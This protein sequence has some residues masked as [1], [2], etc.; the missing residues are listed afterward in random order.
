MEKKVLSVKYS[1]FGRYD[2]IEATPETISKLFQNFAS[3]EFMPNM[4]NLLKIQQPQNT[5][6]QILRPQLINRKL[7]CTISLLPERVDVEFSS[8]DYYEN[9][10]D[11]LRRLIALFDLKI[12]RIALN[13][14][15]VFDNLSGSEI[16]RLNS[17]LT[18]P[19]NYCEERNLVEYSSRRISR[20]TLGAINENVNV[21]RNITSITQMVEGQQ[22]IS[23]IQIDTDINTLGEL[24]RERFNIDDC[25][26]FFDMATNTDRDV[27]NNIEEIANVD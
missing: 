3:D 6:Q 16:V 4:I 26:A 1:I 10:I 19:E 25:Q 18:P 8:N 5:V 14:S 24:T 23:Q 12:N 11:Y 2:Y 7:A 22:L 20:K 15:T 13:T 17:K 27:V 21:G 9:A